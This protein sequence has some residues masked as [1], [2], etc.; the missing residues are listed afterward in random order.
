MGNFG[1]PTKEE[2]NDHFKKRIEEKAENDKAYA[3]EM[4]RRDEEAKTF[5]KFANAAILPIFTEIKKE[6]SSQGIKVE[7]WT[8]LTFLP[9]LPSP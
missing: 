2:F 3:D 6:L 9:C 4:K 8:S 7:S 5:V 1:M